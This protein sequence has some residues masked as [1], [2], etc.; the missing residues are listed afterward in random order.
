M[1]ERRAD[2]L[3]LDVLAEDEVGQALADAFAGGRRQIDDESIAELRHPHVAD[4]PPLRREQRGVAAG[5]GREPGDIVGQQAVQIG[6]SIGAAKLQPA[7][8]RGPIQQ[9][10]ALVQDPVVVV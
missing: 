6:P 5:A 3:N 4:H 8:F 10:G 9:R 7:A 2:V 1:G